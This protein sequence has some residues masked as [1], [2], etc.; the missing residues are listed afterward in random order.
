MQ[1]NQNESIEYRWK[2]LQD[3]EKFHQ[4]EIFLIFCQRQNNFQQW[5]KYQIIVFVLLK[6]IVLNL[7]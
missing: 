2:F 3:N 5:K 7:M 4:N 1:V 6:Q